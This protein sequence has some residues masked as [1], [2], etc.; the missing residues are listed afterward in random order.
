MANKKHLQ[1][2]DYLS[3]SIPVDLIEKL[4]AHCHDNL[5]GKPKHGQQSKIVEA[6]LNGYLAKQGIKIDAPVGQCVDTFEVNLIR[7]ALMTP[8]QVKECLETVILTGSAILQ[9]GLAEDDLRHITLNHPPIIRY[10]MPE[11]F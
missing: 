4:R 9:V 6:L 5:T 7:S 8:T 11:T 3:V 2:H 1:P 10:Q